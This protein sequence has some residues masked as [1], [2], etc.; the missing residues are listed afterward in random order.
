MSRRAA[1]PRSRAEAAKTVGAGRRGL[2]RRNDDRRRFTRGECGMSGR[3][4][5]R[6]RI[7]T[8]PGREAARAMAGVRG[9]LRS[10]RR[11]RGASSIITST[12]RSGRGGAGSAAGTMKKYEHSRRGARS[13]LCP[14]R[15]CIAPQPPPSPPPASGRVE[16]RRIRRI[17]TLAGSCAAF[18][19]RRR[20]PDDA[21]G[22]NS[23][24]RPSWAPRI[25]GPSRRREL[26]RGAFERR[27]ETPH[28]S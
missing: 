12:Y 15:M 2:R 6:R 19:A 23:T 27:K 17:S 13:Q 24:L 3:G 18:T 8:L 4:V 11:G 25:F 21:P 7:C 1:A 28:V 14:N 5:G 20:G 16:V 22:H 26:A 10:R 9:S